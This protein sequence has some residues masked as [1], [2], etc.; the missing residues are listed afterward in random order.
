L[1]QIAI[2]PKPCFSPCFRR[3]GFVNNRMTLG[4]F[5]HS[6][7]HGFSPRRMKLYL[8]DDRLLVCRP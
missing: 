3:R 4:F 7:K 2:F 8:V 5:L 6:F 1:N